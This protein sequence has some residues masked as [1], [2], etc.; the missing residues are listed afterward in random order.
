MQ[1]L[2]PYILFCILATTS[3]ADDAER[4]YDRDESGQNRSERKYDGK[5]LDNTNFSEAIL[6]KTTFR[7]CS[8]KHCNFSG[9]TMEGTDFYGADLT[10]SDFR[11]AK[12]FFLQAVLANFSE[13]NFEGGDFTKFPM[14]N[15]KLH[16]ASFRKATGFTS[17]SFCD[18]AG[19]DFRGADL[20]KATFYESKFAKAKYDRKTRFPSSFDP[21]EAGMIL[22]E[23]Q[24]EDPLPEPKPSP[25]KPKPT[26]G[27]K[28][29]SGEALFTKLDANEDG[30]LSGKEMGEYK[31]RDAND[32]GEITVAEF[33]AGE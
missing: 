6:N 4:K 30:V 7:E 33:L 19:S 8:L 3:I 32:D 23:E 24:D 2:K 15:M 31:S 5:P 22:V 12:L 18:C 10:G 21:E 16:K 1:S 20:S 28:P 25:D 26:P 11:A 13:T 14:S 9:A 27:K 17:I 29:L